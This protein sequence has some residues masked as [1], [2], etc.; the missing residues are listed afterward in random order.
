MTAVMKCLMMSWIKPGV[1]IFEPYAGDVSVAE[2]I[3][4]NITLKTIPAPY[5]GSL[6]PFPYQIRVQKKVMPTN[7]N[8]LILTDEAGCSTPPLPPSQLPLHH[9]L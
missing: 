7:H 5:K 9:D 4:A 6:M 8:R 3:K 1:D 2:I